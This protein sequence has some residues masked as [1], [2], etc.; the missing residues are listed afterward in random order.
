ML[1]QLFKHQASVVP[2]TLAQTLS[3]LEE[4]LVSTSSFQERM[5]QPFPGEE[6]LMKEWEA[7]RAKGKL[8]ESPYLDKYLFFRALRVVAEEQGLLTPRESITL[9]MDLPTYF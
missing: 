9:L 8:S 3:L 7:C 5:G 6:A 4:L 2:A 1:W